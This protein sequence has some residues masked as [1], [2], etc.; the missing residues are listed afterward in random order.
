MSK[1]TPDG[2]RQ[3]VQASRMNLWR[4]EWLRLFRTPRALALGAVFVAFGLIEPVFTKYQD[5]LLAHVGNGIRIYMPPP[6]PAA[7]LSSY[8]SQ[9]SVIGLV[10]VVSLAA[11]ALS[12]DAHRGLATFLRT[13]VRGLWRLVA[14]RFTVNAAAAAIA[15]LLG[16]LAAWYETQVLIGSLPAAAMLGGI[17]CGAVYLTFAVAVTTLAASIARSTLPAVAIALAVLLVLPVVG[18]FRSIENWLPSTLLRAPVDLVSGTHQL[19]HYLPTLAVTVAVTAVALTIAVRRL[20]AR[21]I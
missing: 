6:T 14:P 3:A 17:L 18:T 5:R 19:P 11:G 20:G 8:I 16:S 12:F 2:R 15:Y 9:A 21:E 7:A 13:R 1:A 4:L 10:V